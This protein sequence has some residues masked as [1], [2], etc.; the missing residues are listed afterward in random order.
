MTN[1]S[2]NRVDVDQ[3]TAVGGS[4]NSVRKNGANTAKAYRLYHCTRFGK[5]PPRSAGHSRARLTD[6]GRRC[7]RFMRSL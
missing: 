2:A 1:V 6:I 5:D 3:R 7:G 4:K